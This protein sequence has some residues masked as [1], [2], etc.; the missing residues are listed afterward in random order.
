MAADDPSSQLHIPVT[1][2]DTGLQPLVLWLMGA[3]ITV[4]CGAFGFTH[5]RIAQ[6]REEMRE[7]LDRM[8]ADRDQKQADSKAD[9]TAIWAEIRTNQREAAELHRQLLERLGDSVTRAEL[10][11]DLK[12]TETRIGAMLSNGIARRH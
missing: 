6:V 4:I 9:R 5:V 10:R 8:Q 11:E 7:S 12:A 2:M 1:T 3:A